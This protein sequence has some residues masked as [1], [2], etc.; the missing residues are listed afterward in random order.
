MPQLLVLVVLRGLLLPAATVSTDL[1]LP[2]DES[3]PL[4]GLVQ[5]VEAF[6]SSIDELL[7]LYHLDRPLVA[8]AA[9]LARANAVVRTST[10]GPV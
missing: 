4:R 2:A 8:D 7:A 1:G 3:L 10:S 9:T 6:H 5:L